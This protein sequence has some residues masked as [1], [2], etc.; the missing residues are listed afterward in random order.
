MGYSDQKGSLVIYLILLPFIAL[1]ISGFYK[2]VNRVEKQYPEL[3]CAL[4]YQDV[5]EEHLPGFFDGKNNKKNVSLQKGL[6]KTI[7][8]TSMV[9]KGVSQGKVLLDLYMLEMDPDVSYSLHFSKESLRRGIWLE[10][11]QYRL[12]SVE[13]N[14]LRLKIMDAY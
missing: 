4:D 1:F 13:E 7:D 11:I 10:N 2:S 9:F 14:A 12:V 8:K 5:L 3:S 6:K